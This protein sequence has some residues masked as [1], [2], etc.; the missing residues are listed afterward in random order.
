MYNYCRDLIK[1][2]PSCRISQNKFTCHLFSYG[3]LYE[4]SSYRKEGEREGGGGGK[5]KRGR[6]R[7]GEKEEEKEKKKYLKGTD[8]KDW[9]LIRNKRIKQLSLL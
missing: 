5:G 9:M 8:G 1:G 6:R 2:I 7:T 3:S 4:R